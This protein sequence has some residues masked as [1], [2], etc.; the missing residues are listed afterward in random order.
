MVFG[1]CVS[2]QHGNAGC[3]FYPAVCGSGVKTE[4]QCIN[5]PQTLYRMSVLYVSRY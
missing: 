4:R 3:A 2:E 1:L 5:M